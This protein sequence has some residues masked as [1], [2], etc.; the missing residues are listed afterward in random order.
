M[1]ERGWVDRGF[2]DE[3]TDGLRRA[4]GRARARSTGSE[5]EARAGACRATRCSSFARD[6]RRGASARSSSGAW[7]SPST[8]TARTTCARSSTSALAAGLRRPRGLRADADPR[9]LRRP[10]RRR[11]GLLRDRA[12]RAACRST[13]RTPPS[14]AAQWGFEVPASAGLTAPRD[15]RRRA[16]RASSTCCSRAGGNFLE[17]LPDPD[18]GAA[19]RSA[20]CRCA[21]TWTSCS[22]RRCWSSPAERRCCC[23]RRRPATRSP[24]GSPRRPPSGGS[25]SAPRSR[26][27]GSARRGR[28]GGC[29]GELAA[30][31][32]P[33]LAERRPLRGHRRD[34]RRDRAGRAALRAGSRT[35]AR[36]ATRSSTAGPRLC[37]GW[38]FPTADGRARFQ[39]CRC[40]SRVARRRAP[41][42]LDPAR[43]AVQ[44]DGPGRP[45]RAHRRGARGGADQR[46]RRRAA[47]ARATATPVIVRSRPRRARGPR[48]VAPIARRQRP[49]PLAGGQRAD[50]AR[51]ALARGAACPTTTRGSAS[52]APAAEWSTE[53]GPRITGGRSSFSWACMCD[54]AACRS[55]ACRSQASG[56]SSRCSGPSEGP[57]G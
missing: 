22:R 11:D 50:R 4:R 53:A 26:A 2:V 31:V 16:T 28:S 19:R 55:P 37:E 25:S 21:S 23:C 43:Q 51:P 27:R 9:P 39:P 41:A 13:P 3:H 45:R 36:A 30:R 57:S 18:V 8:T 34:P 1:I 32:R 49:G 54:S 10:G 40:P 33:E 6:G 42:A 29:F 56:R 24:A 20:G 46:R 7:A 47:R 35:C 5:L 14:S 38:E 44:L 48:C 17:V 15:A 52:S 12:S